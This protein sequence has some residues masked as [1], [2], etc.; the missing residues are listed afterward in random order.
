M[1]EWTGKEPD[2]KL[3]GVGAGEGLDSY[4]KSRSRG[5]LGSGSVTKWGTVRTPTLPVVGDG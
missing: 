3:T 5:D 4:G 1:D 2:V